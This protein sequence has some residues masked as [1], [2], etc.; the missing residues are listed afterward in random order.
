MQTN[1]TLSNIGVIL[2]ALINVGGLIWAAARITT[3]MDIF[4]KYMTDN[5]KRVDEQEKKINSIDKDVA[6]LW[7]NRPFKQRGLSRGD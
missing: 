1:L 3:K 2:A 7:E 4:D 5:N 6:V